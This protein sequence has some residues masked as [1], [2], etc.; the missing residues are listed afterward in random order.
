M[1]YELKE[2]SVL[3]LIT[4]YNNGNI[5][6]PKYQRNS[7]W[8]FNQRTNLICSVLKGEN[9][10]QLTL[11]AKTKGSSEIKEKN[12]PQML[13]TK[14]ENL[15]MLDG[16]QRLEAFVE[17]KKEDSSLR[18]YK[19]YSA[20]EETKR[21][22]FEN[23]KISIARYYDL[24]D[25]EEIGLFVRLNTGGSPLKDQEIR[26]AK[27]SKV[28][29]ANELL[30]NIAKSNEFINAT[31]G[32]IDSKN[33]M[34][35]TKL[36]L[37]TLG[38]Y[39]FSKEELEKYGSYP[40]FL[41]KTM[42]ELNNTDENIL[43][44]YEYKFKKAM[45]D[46]YEIFE[47]DNFTMMHLQPHLKRKFINHG[48]FD[49]ITI[50]FMNNNKNYTQEQKEKLREIYLHKLIYDKKFT[51]AVK[52]SSYGPKCRKIDGYGYVLKDRFEIVASYFDQV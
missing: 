4:M 7:V 8:T 17:Y 52:I 21:T 51:D 22:I 38:N 30:E 3:D 44:Q 2:I 37:R 46:T 20:L 36:I 18:R 9:V 5:V 45:K 10:G 11:N 48:I 19:K 39:I 34:L 25:E 41:D 50:Y 33:R 28:M 43:K 1:S 24:S 13:N 23:H 27:F 42:V 32:I 15:E 29:T 35:N 14:E 12:F 40:A 16:L 31:H 26:H 47:I 6:K 49:S